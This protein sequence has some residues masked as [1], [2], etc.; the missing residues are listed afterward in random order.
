MPHQF[1][2]P[3][4]IQTCH[5]SVNEPADSEFVEC[6]FYIQSMRNKRTRTISD[7]SGQIGVISIQNEVLFEVMTFLRTIKK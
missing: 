6:Q 3:R 2:E 4:F 7:F 1:F 5:D